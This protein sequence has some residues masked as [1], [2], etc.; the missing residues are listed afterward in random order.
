MYKV[1]HCDLSTVGLQY[2]ANEG[3]TGF[4]LQHHMAS[5][6]GSD[7]DSAAVMSWVFKGDERHIPQSC[8]SP[9]SLYLL[10]ILLAQHSVTLPVST[11][12][13]YQLP[14]LKDLT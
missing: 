3:L 5:G 9:T 7:G 10:T 8:G 6:L 14:L 12:S 4:V 13:F 11:A 1:C 2:H